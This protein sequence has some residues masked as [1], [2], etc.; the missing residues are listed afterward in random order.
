V[1]IAQ[2]RRDEIQTFWN[3]DAESAQ[4][5]RISRQ[6]APRNSVASKSFAVERGPPHYAGEDKPSTKADEATNAV[7][8]R[9]DRSESSVF[10][11]RA[12]QSKWPLRWPTRYAMRQAAFKRYRKY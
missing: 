4:L 2:S 12:R 8:A 11:G 6:V 3:S 9:P 1:R 7:F 5:R 10:A